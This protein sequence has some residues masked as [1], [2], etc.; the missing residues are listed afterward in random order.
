MALDKKIEEV[1]ILLGFEVESQQWLKDGG[2]M[3]LRHGK[4]T[5]ERDWALIIYKEDGWDGAIGKMGEMLLKVGQLI[6]IQQI[7]S[8]IR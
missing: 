7:N 6:K 4:A 2:W 8:I 5:Q 3:R 1:A